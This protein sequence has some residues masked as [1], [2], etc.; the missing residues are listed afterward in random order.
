M[1]KKDN[2]CI[3]FNRPPREKQISLK[4]IASA[5]FSANFSMFL[6]LSVCQTG[7][8]LQSMKS[9]KSAKSKYSSVSVEFVLLSS[10]SKQTSLQKSS[11][12]PFRSGITISLISKFE[13]WRNHKPQHSFDSELCLVYYRGINYDTRCRRQR[14]VVSKNQMPMVAQEAHGFLRFF[15]IKNS[16]K[17]S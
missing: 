13:D 10:V 5:E 8:A 9:F 15:H 12:Y 7:A 14:K 2:N 3:P 11:S 16:L 4:D 6:C 1:S 17:P